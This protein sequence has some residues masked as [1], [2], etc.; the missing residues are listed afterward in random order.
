MILY[1]DTIRLHHLRYMI[2]F[3]GTNL[4]ECRFYLTGTVQ[5]A[6]THMCTPTHHISLHSLNIRTYTLIDVHI[7]N[8][9]HIFLFCSSYQVSHG[10]QR[11]IYLALPFDRIPC[12][13]SPFNL[14]CNT[15]PATQYTVHIQI[16]KHL[17]K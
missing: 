5:L 11:V 7:H 2:L 9:T 1:R 8:F 17:L 6:L 3:S 12:F 14:P 15:L 13:G 16:C 10:I 4:M